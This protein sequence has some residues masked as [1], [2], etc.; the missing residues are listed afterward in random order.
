MKQRESVI[1]AYNKTAAKYAQNFL[2]EF[3]GKPLDRLLLK[4]FAEENAAKSKVIDLACGPGQTTIL[5]RQYGLRDLTGIDISD[6]MIKTAIKMHPPGINFQVGDMLNLHLKDNSCGA[7]LCF[8]GI[9]HFT[10]SELEK[11]FT[12][13]Y[14]V[15]KPGASFLF[16]FH[17]GTETNSVEEFLGHPVKIDFYFFEVEKVL[18][19][20]SKVGW[21]TIE[22]VERHP[23]KEKEYPSKRAYI[24]LQK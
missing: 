12:E 14:R 3:D 19:I 5:L 10:I 23:Y 7:A 1:K 15:L 4:R 17:V 13:I 20:A 16:S 21:N 2:H 8:Y 11:A 22:V 6:G 18:E 24:T 9:V